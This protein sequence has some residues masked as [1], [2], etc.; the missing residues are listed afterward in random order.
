[1][2]ALGA[3]M[4]QSAGTIQSAVGASVGVSAAASAAG[5]GGPSGA[6]N[7]VRGAQRLAY[8]TKL[9]PPNPDGD[10]GGGGGF[11]TGR[12]GFSRRRPASPPPPPTYQVVIGFVASEPIEAFTNARLA[13]IST[14]VAAESGVDP[15]QVTT[16]AYAYAASTTGQLVSRALSEVLAS[17][18]NSSEGA[19]RAARVEITIVTTDSSASAAAEE[20]LSASV[21]ADAN[22]TSAFLNLQVTS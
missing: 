14:S 20:S 3:L 4:A 9:G 2:A 15:S 17:N 6:G 22:A 13:N 5:G 11:T 12:L 7:A 10:D 1:M 18:A 19:V 8:Y 16:V 21:F